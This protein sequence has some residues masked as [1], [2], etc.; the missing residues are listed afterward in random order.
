MYF[1]WSKPYKTVIYIKLT[2]FDAEICAEQE[3][4]HIFN[5]KWVVPIG[6]AHFLYNRKLHFLLYKKPPAGCALARIRI[7]SQASAFHFGRCWTSVTGAQQ[8]AQRENVPRH[9]LFYIIYRCLHRRWIT[10]KMFLSIRY[11][12]SLKSEEQ[13]MYEREYKQS[14]EHQ[15]IFTGSSV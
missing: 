4:S 8:R 2:S 14:E 12:M 1:I 11:C 13:E 9:I 6:I 3:K 5:N 15:E 10:V 7:M